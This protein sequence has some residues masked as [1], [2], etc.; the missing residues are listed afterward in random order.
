MHALPSCNENITGIY[1][2]KPGFF[3]EGSRV[4]VPF[5]AGEAKLRY[6]RSGMGAGR[7]KGCAY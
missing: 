7:R 6:P 3:L 2:K 1:I 5:L 4:E